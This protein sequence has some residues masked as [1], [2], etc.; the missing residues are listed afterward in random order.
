MKV[1]FPAGTVL[2]VAGAMLA[3]SAAP[4]PQFEDRTARSGIAFVLRN[5]AS[6]EK[7]QIETMPGGVAVFDFDNDG[8]PDIY[9][10]NGAEQ[11]SLK[12][13]G[14]QYRNLLYRNKHDWTFEDVTDRAGVGG[15]GYDI[16]VAAGDYDNDGN[17]D[18]FV[19]GVNGNR[20]F[21][22]RGDGTFADVTH[23][24]GLESHDWSVAAAWVD[25]DN[26]GLVDLFVVNYV[27]WDPS[28]EQ[29]CGDAVRGIR[30][31]CHP[32]FYQPLSDRLYHNDGNG[33]F[34]DVTEA[35][36]IKNY[37]GKGMGIAI[38]DYDHDGWMDIFI[39][40]DTV[41]N[42]L[43]NNDHHGH[44]RDVALHAGVGLNDDGKAVSSM[45]VDFRDLDNDGREDLF[46]TALAN[47][48]FPVFHNLGRGLF[49][50]VTYPS[51][52][53]KIT[54]PLSGWSTGIMDF[55]ND[56]AKDVFVAAGDVQ[57]NTELLSGRKSRQENMLLLNDGSGVFRGV[58][59]GPAALNRGAAFGDFDRDGRIDV[60]VTRLN[61]PPLILRNVMDVGNHWIAIKLIG[62]RSNRDGIGARVSVQANGVSQV[63][64]GTT[65]TGYAC[66]SETPIHF[67][68][69][70]S[71]HADRIEIEWPSRVRQ[72]LTDVPGNSYLTVRE[73]QP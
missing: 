27:K 9:F 43:L 2:L 40:N 10:T 54:I 28:A 8:Y 34:S 12:K 25:Y 3:P 15:T 66:S 68:L 38:A 36:G 45:G 20:L 24:A 26:D 33:V 60:V 4:R 57:D 62:T 1:A 17:A 22:N 18:L 71:P 70:H 49:N 7:H 52:V 14:R 61:E 65:S 67:G 41:A 42:L 51:H 35:S 46:V 58:P 29:F 55:D 32:R 11:P 50:D 56:G 73:P 64:H 72:I 48:A 44:F 31:Y 47:E 37:V 63:N 21:H 23:A 53:G 59:V 6:P 30:S 19:A 13:T 39:A 16:G 69:G 5:A